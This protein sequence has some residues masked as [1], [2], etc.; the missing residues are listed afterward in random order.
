MPSFTLDAFIQGQRWR[1][2]RVRDH[3]GAESDLY[4]VLSE[5]IGKYPAFTPIH[6]VLADMAA[7]LAYLEDWD[8]THA[9]FTLDA[10]IGSQVITLDAAIAGTAS[11]SFTIDAYLNHASSFTLDAVLVGRLTLDAFIV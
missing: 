3:T 9:S 7:R 11:G 4:V 10:V 2:H 5:D 1:H 8:R 6:H